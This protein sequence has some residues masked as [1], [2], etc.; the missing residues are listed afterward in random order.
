MLLLQSQLLLHF[1]LATSTLETISSLGVLAKSHL[2]TRISEDTIDFISSKTWNVN[3]IEKNLKNPR[4]IFYLNYLL[5]I[6]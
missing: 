6:G 3:L 2:T 4:F 1:L 5:Y